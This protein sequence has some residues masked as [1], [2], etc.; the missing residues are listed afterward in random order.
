MKLSE[1]ISY[2]EVGD[3][4]NDARHLLGALNNG[5]VAH[6]E[7]AFISDNDFV[8]AEDIHLTEPAIVDA[9]KASIRKT[10]EAAITAGLAELAA[11]GVELDDLPERAKAV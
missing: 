7:V 4:V 9:I 1:L 2:C 3:T 6:V 5:R 10:C 11:A 8:I